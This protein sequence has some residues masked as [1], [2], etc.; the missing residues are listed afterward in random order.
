MIEAVNKAIYVAA[1]IIATEAALS[2][3][4]GAVSGKNHVAS[5][6]GEAP[7]ADTHFLDR[8]IATSVTSPLHAEV[9]VFAPYAAK[10]EFG[11][12]KVAERPF[13][14]PATEKHRPKAQ[15]LL[16]EAVRRVVR[17]EGI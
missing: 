6:P 17:G 10:L 3:T 15:R 14:R 2:I 8:S 13:L 5:K 7:N 12:S 9:N 4:A 16:K 1:D 11:D